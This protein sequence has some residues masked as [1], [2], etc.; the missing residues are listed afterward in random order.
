[1][2]IQCIK[3]GD[4]F[5]IQWISIG[6]EQIDLEFVKQVWRAVYFWPQV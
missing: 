3:M 6:Y 2:D 4:E 1:M 5:H